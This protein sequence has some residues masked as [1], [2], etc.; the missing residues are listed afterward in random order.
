VVLLSLGLVTA[1]WCILHSL[2]ALESLKKRAYPYC[3]PT[4]YRLFYTLFS[5]ISL[6][7][8]ALIYRQGEGPFIVKYPFP[9]SLTVMALFAFF[10]AVI[11]YA[12]RGFDTKGF[13]GLKEENQP[14]ITSGLYRYSRHPMYAAS[15]GLLWTRD[16]QARDLVVN[17]IFSV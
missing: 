13:L 3:P 15:I 1:A 6:L 8:P 4:A 9:Y 7:P 14:L 10:F 5:L 17:L 16:L 11:I 2:F 12:F